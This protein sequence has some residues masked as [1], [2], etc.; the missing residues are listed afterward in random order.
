MQAT[1]EGW[2]D[3]GGGYALALDGGK[4]KCRNA[5]GKVLSAVPKPVKASEAADQLLALRDWLALHER[6]CAQEVERWMLR[7]LP[8]PRAVLVSVWD[9]PAWRAP[10]QDAV[11]RALDVSGEPLEG[12]TGF[13]RD[14]DPKRGIGVVDLD[15]E[16]HWIGSDRILVPHPIL[17][18]ELNELRELATELGVSQS[19]QQLFRETFHKPARIES[20]TVSEFR[21]GKFAQL[22]HALGRAKS[23]GYRVRGGFAV[24]PVW[25]TGH[26]VEA[27]YWI[28]SEDPMAETWTGELLWV[29]AREH[30]LALPSVPPI[31]WSEGMR[32][33]SAI[34]AGRVVE[35]AEG[36][37]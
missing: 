31:A 13:L 5:T 20:A 15:G 3:A 7:S 4:L 26:V 34:Y 14:V 30:A 16:T 22:V 19:V 33:A 23:L 17:L 11:V 25:E 6:E 10:L 8:V 1:D 2:V 9:D 12:A 24:C 35:T 37:S 28:G 32:M 36:Q 21:E 29:D 27:R 18:P